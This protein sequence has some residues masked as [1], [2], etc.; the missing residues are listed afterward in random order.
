M[1]RVDEI[2]DDDYNP[3]RAMA[4]RFGGHDNDF[5]QHLL[6][7]DALMLGIGGG[8][9]GGGGFLDHLPR[10][11]RYGGA[12]PGDEDQALFLNSAA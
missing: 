4:H 2:D 1:R 10:P 9:L 11:P 8:A 12:A 7:R 3:F 5:L 6:Q